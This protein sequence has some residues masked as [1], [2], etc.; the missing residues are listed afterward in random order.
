M[1]DNKNKLEMDQILNWFKAGEKKYEDF[2]IGTEHEKFLFKQDGFKRLGYDDKNGIRKILEEISGNEEWEK[3][4]EDGH[5]IGLKHFSGSSISLEPG[6]QFELS[7][8]PLKNL[9]ETCKEAGR[10]LELMKKIS[11]KYGFVLIGIGHDPKWKREDVTWMPKKRYEIMKKYMPKVGA[12]GL[13][14]ML[15]TCTIQVNLDY[16]SENDMIKKFQTSIALQSVATALFA[17]SPFVEGKPSGFLSRRAYVWTDTDNDRTGIPKNIF[18]GDFGYQS[19]VDYLMS[20]PMYFIYRDGKYIDVSGQN[21]ADFMLGKLQGLEGL[22][23]TLNDWENHTT[24]AFPEVRLKQFLEMRGADGGP[25]NRI[26]A[27]PALWVGLLYDEKSLNDAHSLSKEFMQ[28]DILEDARRSSAKFGLNG[29]IGKIEISELAKQV[30]EISF[31]GLK[32]RNKLDKKGVSETQ[33]LDPLFNILEGGETSAEQM[34]YKFENQ[35]DK[36]IDKIFE[37][38]IF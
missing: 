8:A 4:I 3:I 26:C 10:H 5:T 6:G 25:W 13:D 28:V 32:R 24:V 27:L 16:S 12:L 37:N 23:P 14:M 34:L 31:E 29:R 35:W 17:N 22:F 33:F 36:N 21:F 2:L 18:D 38:E 1:T 19:W 30:L 9:H 20:V 11:K 15:R 7:G